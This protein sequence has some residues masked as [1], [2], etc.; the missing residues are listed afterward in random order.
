MFTSKFHELEVERADRDA[1]RIAARRARM[2]ER[3]DRFLDARARTVGVPIDALDRQVAEKRRVE[4]AR[5]EEERAALEA[6][7][8]SIALARTL[9]EETRAAKVRAAAA[10]AAT[11]D[12]QIAAKTLRDTADLEGW[13][14]PADAHMTIRA[15]RDAR[16]LDP[17]PR[18]GPSSAQIMDGEDPLKD[19]RLRMQRQQM[20][21][22][23]V[24]ASAEKAARRAAE[25]AAERVRAEELAS[26]VA[27]AEELDAA[28][29]EERRRRA[30]AA[31]AENIA[32]AEARRRVAAEAAAVERA[33]EAESLLTMTR[34]APGE[35][36][37]LP[38]LVQQVSFAGA[39]CADGVFCMDCWLGQLG[40]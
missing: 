14:R 29:A 2:A 32:A 33:A 19:E 20:A 18:L 7:R 10:A 1:A 34:R 23:T 39:S 3:T 9:E 26:A 28:A 27:L 31:A 4:E 8:Q 16:G 36:V 25:Q 37:W 6:T 5:R 13:R 12:S 40:Q 21:A 38:R 30:A 35:E 17:D 22:W 24:A 15:D 11:L